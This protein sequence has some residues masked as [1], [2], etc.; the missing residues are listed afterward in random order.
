M[1]IHPQRPFLCDFT[2]LFCIYAIFLENVDFFLFFNRLFL[3][4]RCIFPPEKKTHERSRCQKWFRFPFPAGGCGGGVMSLSAI[5]TRDKVMV[6]AIVVKYREEK[7]EKKLA[8]ALRVKRRRRNVLLFTLHY[9]TERSGFTSKGKSNRAHRRSLSPFLFLFF[10]RPQLV[11]YREWETVHFLLP[12][13]VLFSCCLTHSNK[14]FFLSKKSLLYLKKIVWYPPD[15]WY[16]AI[17]DVWY[18]YPATSDIRYPAFRLARYPDARIFGKT[19]TYLVH[20]YYILRFIVKIGLTSRILSKDDKQI[21]P[22]NCLYYFVVAG[23][24]GCSCSPPRESLW[25]STA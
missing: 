17:P 19:S 20:P 25:P 10:L 14:V 6:A 13:L 15:I 11:I 9:S 12:L 22:Y 1:P 16:P 18:R 23:I 3:R 24:T 7:K 21:P 5:N 8:R 2:F 4:Q